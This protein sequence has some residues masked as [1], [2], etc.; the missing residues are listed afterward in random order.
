MQ[1]S[2]EAQQLQKKCEVKRE[3]QEVKI[4]DFTT[5]IQEKEENLYK[6]RREKITSKGEL[7]TSKGELNTCEG[8]LMTE[9]YEHSKCKNKV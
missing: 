4:L 3:E 8:K 7:N 5:Q 6:M 2:N 9:K 1:E